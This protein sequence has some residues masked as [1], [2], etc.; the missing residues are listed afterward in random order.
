MPDGNVEAIRLESI[1]GESFL[2]MGREDGQ[3]G[4]QTTPQIW[5]RS[6]SNTP[7]D[8]SL[9]YNSGFKA[10]GGD[11]NNGSGNLDVLVSNPSAFTVGGNTVWNAG[12]TLIT[13]TNTGST[14]TTIGGVSQFDSDNPDTNVD[15]RSL[16]MRDEDGNFAA[17][18]IEA[19]LDGTATGNLPIDGGKLDGG[20]QIGD[21]NNDALLD[22]YGPTTLNGNLSV[23][24]GGEF[25]V[26]PNAFVANPTDGVGIGRIPETKLD[27]FQYT[28]TGTNV[29]TTM[30]RLTNN[31]GTNGTD[32]DITGINGQKTFIDFTFQDSDDNFTPQVRIGAQVGITDPNGVDAGIESEGSGSFVVYT[33]VGSGVSGAGTLSEK[34]RVGPTGNVGINEANPTNKLHVSGGTIYSDQNIIAKN[35]MSIG[36][37][38]ANAGAA[39]LFLGATGQ[40]LGVP[41]SDQTQVSNFRLGNK[42]VGD[43]IF[44]I[45]ANSGADGP[46]TWKATPA[47]AIQGSYNRVAINT[48]AFKGTDNTGDTP[49]NRDYILNVQGDVNFNGQLFQDNAEF[50]TSRWTESQNEIDIYRLS[51]VGIGPESPQV[52]A[53]TSELVVG[54]D[55]SMYSGS[56]VGDQTLTGGSQ[57]FSPGYFGVDK[58]APIN[59]QETYGRVKYR[60]VNQGEYYWW[61]LIVSQLAATPTNYTPVFGALIKTPSGGVVG[62]I[63]EAD[64]DEA[65]ATFGN[66]SGFATG[67]NYYLG[68]LSTA[69]GYTAPTG[70]IFTDATSGGQIDYVA[71]TTAPATNVTY[72]VATTNSGS[73]IHIQLIPEQSILSVNGDKQWIDSYGLIKRNRKNIVEN[74]IIGSNDNCMSVGALT[75]NDN[76]VVTIEQGGVWT[77]V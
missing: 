62:E 33:G 36:L 56:I 61:V 44:E 73:V 31:V 70:D 9:W 24:D 6:S 38:N 16:V 10:S 71:T 76:K 64:F 5:F 46:T 37:A 55:L 34:F 21:S 49:V 72:T 12:N 26:G 4:S 48:T 20:L 32:G 2:I 14:Y 42:L 41:T 63:L 68:W 15:L 43:D 53:P 59:K 77:I 11:D 74:I 23:L 13:A 18:I 75:I 66:P 1:G 3:Q 25:V 60:R 52:I 8:T 57:W 47:I 54:G 65:V 58:A 30:L 40:E 50:V 28:N 29:G 69:P 45:T 27:I 35:S 39:L 22:V 7:A 67:F 19:D 17:N 51:K